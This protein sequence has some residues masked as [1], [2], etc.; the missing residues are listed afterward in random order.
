MNR[1]PYQV[2]YN[3]A[4]EFRQYVKNELPEEE[5]AK[6]EGARRVMEKDIKRWTKVVTHEK[7]AELWSEYQQPA[8]DGKSQSSGGFPRH[9]SLAQKADRSGK[10][11]SYY[12]NLSRAQGAILIQMR[13]GFIGLNSFLS[14][15]KVCDSPSGL[16]APPVIPMQCR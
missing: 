7:F 6:W 5:V 15:M 10:V 4:I 2:Q 3:R 12:H 14:F 16:F 11:L 8:F 1:N 13:T 9:F